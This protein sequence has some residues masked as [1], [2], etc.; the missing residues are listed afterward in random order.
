MTIAYWTQNSH[1]RPGFVGRGR[2]AG[3]V[4]LQV[5]APREIILLPI[6]GVQ[7]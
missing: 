2:A 7:L 1:L 5:A 6:C 4:M 3:G